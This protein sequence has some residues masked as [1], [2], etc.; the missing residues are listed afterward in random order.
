MAN[1]TKREMSGG[2][3][4]TQH[5]FEVNHEPSGSF[6]DARGDVADYIKNANLFLH[7]NIGTNTVNFHDSPDGVKKDVALASFKNIAY[8]VFNPENRS[9]FVDKASSFWNILLKHKHYKMFNPTRFGCRTQV[10]VPTSKSF[11]QVKENI[12]NSFYKITA[13][14]LLGGKENDIQLVFDFSEG[15]FKVHL[16][17]GPMN[18]NEAAMHFNFKSDHFKKC[19]LYINT[20]YYKTDGLNNSSIEKLLVDASRLSW[21]RIETIV[22]SLKL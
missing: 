19:G 20:D 8:F 5:V 13:R 11:E 9:Y 3:M 17:G 4:L 21:S 18:K 15:Q 10:F 14:E 16:F 22:S 2:V 12:F 6:I 1:K 7:W